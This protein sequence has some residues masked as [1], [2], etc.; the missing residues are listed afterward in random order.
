M[1]AYPPKQIDPNV[2]SVVNSD[3]ASDNFLPNV[4]K[5]PGIMPVIRMSASMPNFCSRSLASET[6]QGLYNKKYDLVIISM[7]FSD[8]YFSLVHHLKVGL[9]ADIRLYY[10]L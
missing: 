8:C 7:F 2:E 3:F 6:T 5:E 1:T 9:N 4:F 10:D